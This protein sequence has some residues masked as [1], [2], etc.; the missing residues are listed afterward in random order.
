MRK[1]TPAPVTRRVLTTH[2]QQLVA[3]PGGCLGD[4]LLAE[5]RVI[6]RSNI[7]EHFVRVHGLGFFFHGLDCGFAIEAC[8][9]VTAQPLQIALRENPERFTRGPRNG[10]KDQA[11]LGVSTE[12]GTFPSLLCRGSTEDRA[13]W[14]FAPKMACAQPSWE[15]DF[16]GLAQPITQFAPLL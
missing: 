7:Q 10:M 4:V 8:K 5:L 11:A 6:V 12:F 15:L 9:V 1:E 2:Q 3:L 16:P 14:A 13:C